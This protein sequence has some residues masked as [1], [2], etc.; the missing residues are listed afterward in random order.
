MVQLRVDPSKALGSLTDAQEQQLPFAVAL[1][2]NRTAN[3]AQE[4]ERYRLKASFKLR[5]ESFNLRGV[6]ISKQDRANKSTWRAVIQIQADRDYLNKFEQGGEQIPHGR[7]RWI[8]N[9]DVFK[10]RIIGAGDPLNPK[11]LKFHKD[12][13]GRMLGN[14]RT[15]MVRTKGNGQLLVLQREDRRLTKGSKGRLGKLTLDNFK[16]GQGPATKKQKLS[17]QRTAG[18]RML[19]RLTTRYK[20]RAQ[21]EFYDTVSRTVQDVFPARMREAMDQAMR[22]AK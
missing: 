17:L 10:S 1:A 22:S 18:V 9:R 5:R 8:P 7:Y 13:S 15:F 4:A 16:G 21:L 2:I 20:V 12:P 6:Y 19:Y 11:N 3:D 14:E